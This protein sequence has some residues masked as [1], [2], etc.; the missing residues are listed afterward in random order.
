M[1]K[2]GDMEDHNL[3]TKHLN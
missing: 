3:E 2:K 1:H